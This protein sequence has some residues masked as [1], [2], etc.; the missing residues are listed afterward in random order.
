MQPDTHRPAATAVGLATAELILAIQKEF[1]KVRLMPCEPIE[2]EDVHLWAYL[3]MS[4]EEQLAVQDRI[5]A[6]EHSVQDNTTCRR[7]SWLC[8]SRSEQH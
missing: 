8:R 1:P 2:G 6:I 5:V 7:L 4:A 3:P